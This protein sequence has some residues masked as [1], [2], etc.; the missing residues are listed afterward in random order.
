MKSVASI[1]AGLL[2]RGDLPERVTQTVRGWGHAAGHAWTWDDQAHG[3]RPADFRGVLLAGVVRATL[4]GAFVS[5]VAVRQEG[6]HAA[7]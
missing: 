1:C 7:A 2:D 5:A 3:Y 6:H 4:G